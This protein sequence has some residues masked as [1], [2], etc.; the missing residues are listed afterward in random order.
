MIC[1]YFSKFALPTVSSYLLVGLE[2]FCDII[3]NASLYVLTAGSPC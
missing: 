2:I 1:I 3:F